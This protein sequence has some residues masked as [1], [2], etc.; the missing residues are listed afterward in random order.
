MAFRA[1]ASAEMGSGHLMRC[2]T[3]A[4]A[5]RARGAETQVLSR[6]LPPALVRL[7]RDR[8][9]TFSPLREGEPNQHGDLAHAAWLRVSQVTDAAACAA[10]LG[11]SRWDWIVVD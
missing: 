9:H 7:I 3:L 6:H 8:Q 1:D 11:A 5:M 10:A 2:L 4:D